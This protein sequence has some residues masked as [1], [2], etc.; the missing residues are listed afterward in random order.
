MHILAFKTDQ[1]CRTRAPGGVQIADI[2][3]EGHTRCEDIGRGRAHRAGRVFAGR[4]DQLLVGHLGLTTGLTI[5]G[6]GGAMVVWQTLLAFF[7]LLRG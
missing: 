4:L 5:N 3:G 1:A 2:V 7:R 6:P